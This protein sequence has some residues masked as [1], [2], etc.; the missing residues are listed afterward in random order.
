LFELFEIFNRH[1]ADL[2]QKKEVPASFVETMTAEEITSSTVL[3]IDFN[4]VEPEDYPDFAAG[5]GLCL[6]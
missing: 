5:P 6:F 4:M 1:L 2:I 3:N